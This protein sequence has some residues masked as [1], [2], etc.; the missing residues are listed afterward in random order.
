MSKFLIATLLFSSLF[1]HA[2][3]SVRSGKND[4][5][6]KDKTMETKST[7]DHSGQTTTLQGH[8]G[9]KKSSERGTRA[10]QN[11]LPGTDKSLPTK[12]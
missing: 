4:G 3:D 10:M 1:S 7:S 11:T 8:D 5:G 6:K 12:E 2:F 9:S